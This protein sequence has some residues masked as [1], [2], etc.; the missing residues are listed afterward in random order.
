MYQ[1]TWRIFSLSLFLSSDVVYGVKNNVKRTLGV[2]AYYLDYDGISYVPVYRTF[3]IKDFEGERDIATLEIYPLRFIKDGEGIKKTL[4][5]RGTWF[6]QAIT[7]KHLS[8]DGWTLT[9]GP[10]GI[11]SELQSPLSVDHID[12]DVIIDFV[13]GYKS[14]RSLAS[15]GPS[16]WKGRPSYPKDIAWREGEDYIEII[17]WK[18]LASS[19][20]L[21]R[22]VGIREEIFSG[23]LYGLRAHFCFRSGKVI[24]IWMTFCC[25]ETEV[26]YS[27]TGTLKACKT[28][29]L[30]VKIFSKILKRRSSLRT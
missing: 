5:E 14:E 11:S 19:A 9:C 13:E 12:G 3:N 10:T 16:S 29:K 20:R 18:P 17:H 7:E 27:E 26:N 4:H 2:E 8:C 24:L 6:R 28:S 1:T 23:E 15:F 25:Q 30:T 21:E 22:F